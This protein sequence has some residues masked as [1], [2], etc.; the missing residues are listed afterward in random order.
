M[1][2][3]EML[4]DLL[5][6]AEKVELPVELLIEEMKNLFIGMGNPESK[7]LIVGKEA[8]IG[9]KK[10]ASDKAQIERDK[11]QIEREINNNIS[12]WNYVINEQWDI[13]IDKQ[14]SKI[15]KFAVDENGTDNYSP[16]Y[17]YKGH[18][19]TITN[20]N[21]KKSKIILNG[22]TSRTWFNYQKLRD[23]IFKKEE[24]SPNVNFHEDYFF[25][26][27]NQIPSRYSG[28][29]KTKVRKE[30]IAIRSKTIFESE[31]IQSFPVVILACGPSYISKQDICKLFDVKPFGQRKGVDYG[32]SK[33]WYDTY[34]NVHEN[35]P[36]MVVHTWQLGMCI[37]DE[38]LR[39]IGK[40]I[41]DFLQRK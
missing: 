28:Q 41:S 14:W 9:D 26:E 4:K 25:T 40:D 39:M 32:E 31:F 11:K 21:K 1:T 22:G 8:S 13:V 34:K 5:E 3:K 15:P 33:Q 27:L 12:Q 6:K 7:I 19:N 38:Y 2:R 16:L 36:K 23:E 30:I 37:A 24:K 20:E 35:S 29:Q 18:I 17:P 10:N